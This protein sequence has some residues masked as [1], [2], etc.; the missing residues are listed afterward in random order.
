MPEHPPGLI[1]F[2]QLLTW[3][4][5]FKQVTDPSAEI[6]QTIHQLELRLLEIVTSFNAQQGPIQ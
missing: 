6:R 3:H 5:Y 4:G 1:T 2:D